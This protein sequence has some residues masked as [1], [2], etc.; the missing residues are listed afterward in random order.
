MG[1]VKDDKDSGLVEAVHGAV[2]AKHLTRGPQ[3]RRLQTTG[4]LS[5]VTSQH[6]CHKHC[7]VAFCVGRRVAIQ[8]RQRGSLGEVHALSVECA[9]KDRIGEAPR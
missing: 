8:Y 5:I 6:L 9:Y 4:A 1:V 7:L 2:V 3:R